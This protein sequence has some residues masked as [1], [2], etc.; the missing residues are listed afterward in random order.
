MAFLEKSYDLD[1]MTLA[2][3][4]GGEGGAELEFSL[5]ELAKEMF[6]QLACHGAS[7]K[8]GDSIASLK[9]KLEKS[10]G[11]EPSEE[12]MKSSALETI[13]AVWEQLKSGDWRATRG[14][15][16]AKPRVG[17]VA[18][19]IARLRNMDLEEV[20]KLVAATDK[21]KVKAWRAH[22]QIQAE[23]AKIRAERA[24][25]RLQKAAV[26]ADFNPFA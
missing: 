1:N 8:L 10:L 13:N 15:G 2:F 18:Q 12:E 3:T 7:Q 11:R 14:E 19:A 4:V 22:P 21:E 9:T 24:A 25:E 6:D 23:I 26:G 20:V 5:S 16:E 17:E